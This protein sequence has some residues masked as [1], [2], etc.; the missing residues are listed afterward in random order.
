MSIEDLQKEITQIEDAITIY[1][2][3]IINLENSLSK[4][5]K[6]TK[7]SIIN[8]LRTKKVNA[9]KNLP[10]NN[11]T[12]IRTKYKEPIKTILTI[13]KTIKDHKNTIDTLKA[14]K[15]RKDALT[16]ILVKLEAEK[17]NESS[18]MRKV[19]RT[20]LDALITQ[21]GKIPDLENKK[22]LFI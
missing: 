22:I 19:V 14:R 1:N 13:K 12:K 15:A 17:Y 10:E 11:E 20:G 9:L 3:T 8:N 18:Y 21:K 2:N 4:L 7:S 6:K 5:K 16:K